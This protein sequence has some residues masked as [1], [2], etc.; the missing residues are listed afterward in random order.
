M[1]NKREKNLLEAFL[2][3]ADRTEDVSGVEDI[4][5]TIDLYVCVV[6]KDSELPPSEYLKPMNKFKQCGYDKT[7]KG[8]VC[9]TCLEEEEIFDR[10]EL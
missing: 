8:K 9:D 1:A 2:S 5:Q 6:C 7:L 4:A 10:E 3:L